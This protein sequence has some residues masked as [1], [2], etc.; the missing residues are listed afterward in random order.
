MLTLATYVTAPVL[1]KLPE[2]LTDQQCVYQFGDPE[3]RVLYM[4]LALLQLLATDY[5][6]D[7]VS[8]SFRTDRKWKKTPT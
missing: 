3:K 7:C 6:L 4:L 8:I 1:I 5:R 2:D